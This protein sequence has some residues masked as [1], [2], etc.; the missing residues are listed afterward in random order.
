MDRRE[1][2]LMLGGAMAAAHA[3]HAEQKAMP[4]IGFL[5][6]ASPSPFARLWPRSDKDWLNPATSPRG[7]SGVDLWGYFEGIGVPQRPAGV[8]RST[9]SSKLLRWVDRLLSR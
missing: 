5:G 7:Q 3:S 9:L 6:L 1:F 8:R 2:M 4:V